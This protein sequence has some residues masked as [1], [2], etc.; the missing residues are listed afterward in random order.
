MMHLATPMDVRQ[1]CSIVEFQ[2]GT[3]FSGYLQRNASRLNVARSKNTG[4]MRY[5]YIDGALVLVLRPEEGYFSLPPAGGQALCDIERHL[6]VPENGIIVMDDVAQF[7]K[8]GKSVFA[9]HVKDVRDGLRPAQD[10]YI[11]TG[12]RE[13]LAVGKT[14]LSSADMRAFSR[15]VAVKVRHGVKDLAIDEDLD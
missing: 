6:P 11:C 12:A 15:G 8:D 2:F 1:I 4:K 3:T 5:I 14:V 9:K 7:I 13:F 10:V